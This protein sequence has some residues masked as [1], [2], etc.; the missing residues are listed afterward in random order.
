M[1]VAAATDDDGDSERWQMLTSLPIRDISVG[2]RKWQ[3]RFHRRSAA[4]FVLL[5]EGVPPE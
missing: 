1:S 4:R 3:T 5:E 2:T